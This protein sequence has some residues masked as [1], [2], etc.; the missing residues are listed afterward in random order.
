M[1]INIKVTV[2]PNAKK[3]SLIEMNPKDLAICVREKTE[4][5]QANRRMCELVADHF[6]VSS[7]S[8]HI[9]TG[10]RARSKILTVDL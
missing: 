4:R 6:G 9:M 2:T 8:V 5:N 1:S 7:R 10:H 3:E